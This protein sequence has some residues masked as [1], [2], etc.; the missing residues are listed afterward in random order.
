MFA[1]EFCACAPRASD[2]LALC[3]DPMH[4]L[5]VNSEGTRSRRWW[6]PC[7]GCRLN[8]CSGS[9]C[10]SVARSRGPGNPPVWICVCTWFALLRI[11]SMFSSVSVYVSVFIRLGTSSPKGIRECIGLSFDYLGDCRMAWSVLVRYYIHPL[12]AV[13]ITDP[14]FLIRSLV[15]WWLVITWHRCQD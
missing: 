4:S 2:A 9:V 14:L 7:S 6:H 5:A 3:L 8:N 11:G 12:R 15:I 1:Q 10:V 13:L